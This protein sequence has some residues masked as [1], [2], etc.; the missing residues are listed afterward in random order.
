MT[1]SLFDRT[2]NELPLDKKPEQFNADSI[3]VLRDVLEYHNHRYYVLDDPVISDSEYDAFYRRLEA[4][5][6]E[7]PELI[8][9]TSPTQRVGG[10]ALDQFESV[11]HRFPMLSL[12]NSTTPDELRDFDK[13]LR[14]EVGVETIDYV[15]EHKIDGLAVSITYESGKLVLGATRGDGTQGENITSNVKTIRSVPLEIP[16]DGTIIVQGEAFIGTGDFLIF[17]RA[18]EEKGEKTYANPRNTAAGSLRQLDSRITAT[19]P[20]DCFMHSIRNY[21][22]LSI[23]HHHDALKHLDTL[24]FKVTPFRGLASGIDEVIIICEEQHGQRDKLD[25][26]IDGLVVKVDEFR[27]QEIAGFVARAPRFAIAYKYPP[28]EGTTVVLDIQASVGRT[29]TLTPVATF[30]PLLLDGSTVTHASLY[31]MDEIERKDIRVGDKVIIAKGGDVIPKVIK[32]LNAESDEHKKRPEFKMPEKCPICGSDVV[33]D[34]D[35]VDY[36]CVSTNCR[37]VLQRRIEHYVSKACMRIEGMGPKIVERF[38]DEGLI[39]DIPDLYILNFDEIATMPGF[40]EKSAENLKSEIEGSKSQPLWRMIHGISIPGI[41]AEVAKLL[42]NKLGSYS[43]IT[44]ADQESLADINGIGPVLAENIFS[45]FRDDERAPILEGLKSAGLAAFDEVHDVVTAIEGASGPFAGKTVVLTG[46]LSQFS[47]DEM[48][49]KLES[50][51]AKVTG[52]VSKNTDYVIVGEN[53][54]SKFDKAQK[55]G[56]AILRE[57][58]AIGMINL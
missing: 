13:R 40:G 43:A 57:E 36:K 32:V 7:N 44:S 49:E 15:V 42:V 16:F 54:G 48:K 30:E 18:Q 23:A 12:Q 9:P 53:P 24:G 17:N 21:E 6:S 45:F 31:N 39:K 55:L 19:R 38:L 28:T 14:K 25:Y 56:V 1:G 10:R 2:S 50:A 52:S 22:E 26:G 3:D 27:L 47:R 11:E 33:K 51:G 37:A 8:T 34:D 58:D 29:G 35:A 41:G 4:L 46:A 20:L 5:E